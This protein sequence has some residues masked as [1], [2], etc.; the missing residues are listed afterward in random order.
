MIHIGRRLLN[1]QYYKKT[2]T[3]DINSKVK[4]LNAVVFNLANRVIT[5]EKDIVKLQ[6]INKIVKTK[7]MNNK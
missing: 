7:K 5:L 4:E 2:D 1:K 3:P 6:N